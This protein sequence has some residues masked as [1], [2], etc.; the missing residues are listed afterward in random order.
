MAT[1]SKKPGAQVVPRT[2]KVTENLASQYGFEEKIATDTKSIESSRTK[3]AD[4]KRQLAEETERRNATGGIGAIGANLG[5]VNLKRQIDAENK[6]IATLTSNINDPTRYIKGDTERQMFKGAKFAEGLLG[7]EGLGRLGDDAEVQ[8]TLQ[9]FKDISEQGLSRQ[10]VEAERAAAFQGI[11]RNT[12]TSQRA[13]QAALARAGVKGAT[14]GQ[15]LLQG[16]LGGLTA[17]AGVER[18]LFLKSEQLKREG[19]ADYSQRLGDVK[20]FDIS[21]AASEKDIALQTGLAFAQMK[22]AKDIAA[23]QAQAQ[24]AAAR[25]RSAAAC[26]HEDVEVKMVTGKYK[27]ISQ[28]K[29]GEETSM[30]EVMGVSKYLV[31]GS[32]LVEVNGN[33]MTNQHIIFHKG[34]YI[35]AEEIGKKL[36]W[37]GSHVVYDVLIDG[38]HLL[39]LSNDVLAT[40]QEA[41]DYDAEAIKDFLNEFTTKV[42]TGTI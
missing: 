11:D 24:E 30:G 39:E 12:Q 9:R 25:A 27:K 15:Q 32:E 3:L 6:R 19:L 4:L 23:V 14:A 2:S 35:L 37:S 21:Q 26:F 31:E 16:E 1:D 41:M 36:N 38:H 7:E 18:D 8:D 5:R 33:I 13:L 42:S 20:T 28:I 22:S 10:E 29:L 40:D 34:K 17:K